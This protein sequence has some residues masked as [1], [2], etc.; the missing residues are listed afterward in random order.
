M[1]FFLHHFFKPFW[2][3]QK[4]PRNLDWGFS[5]CVC[6]VTSVISD[7]L[8]PHGLWSTRLLCPWDSPG[9]NTGVGCHASRRPFQ[10]RDQTW[11]SCIVVRFFTAEH[12]GK[13]LR[14]QMCP[15]LSYRVVTQ[16]L[17][18]QEE[19]RGHCLLVRDLKKARCTFR[20]KLR[21]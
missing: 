5:M 8:R 13:P 15:S 7:S 10:P 4:W 1:P 12:P 6:S 17:Y 11:V 14:F 19:H 3:S 18:P 9:K 16:R 2:S 21:F 20:K